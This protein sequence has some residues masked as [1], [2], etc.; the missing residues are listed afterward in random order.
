LRRKIIY[1]GVY[2]AFLDGVDVS[3][4]RFYA[5]DESGIVKC[6]AL[7]EGK[8][9]LDPETAKVAET[10]STGRVVIRRRPVRLAPETL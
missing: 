5:D 1:M 2:Q 3:N 10:V 7:R 6:N 8:P 4:R 9:Y